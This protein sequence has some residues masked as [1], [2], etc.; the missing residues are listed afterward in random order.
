MPSRVAHDRR[1][2]VWKAAVDLEG[3]IPDQRPALRDMIEK[4]FGVDASAL[5]M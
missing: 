3:L 1:C 4:R 5:M 2:R